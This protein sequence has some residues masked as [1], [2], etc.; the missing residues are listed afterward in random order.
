MILLLK[1]NK[2]TLQLASQY[3][4]CTKVFGSRTWH[5]ILGLTVNQETVRQQA[6]KGASKLDLKA[7]SEQ[8]LTLWFANVGMNIQSD[9]DRQI[10][11]RQ[12]QTD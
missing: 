1:Q 12:T 9:S 3:V 5:F 11:S 7:L 2:R 8:S 6:E 10:D 4:V